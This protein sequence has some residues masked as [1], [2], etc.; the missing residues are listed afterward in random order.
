VAVG[1]DQCFAG[2]P[3]AFQVDLVADAVAGARQHDAELLRDAHQIAVIV[4]VFKADLNR[5]VVDVADGELRADPGD[6]HGFKLQISQGARGV[7]GER[8]V[9]A[10]ADF[11]AG[12]EG[13]VNQMTGED[14]FHNVFSHGSFLTGKLR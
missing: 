5:I 6:V 9:D 14:L 12:R 1:A 4:R 2:T 7:L 11:P 10:D 3:E 8:L 13:A